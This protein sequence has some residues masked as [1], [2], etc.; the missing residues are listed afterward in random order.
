MQRLSPNFSV[1]EY[2]IEERS[3]G[4]TLN[5]M[6]PLVSLD[7]T[8]SSQGSSEYYGLSF[9][10]IR[11]LGDVYLPLLSRLSLVHA[12]VT[13]DV[14][15]ALICNHRKTL[16]HLN[17]RD[18]RLPSPGRWRPVLE[19]LLDVAVVLEELHLGAMYQKI[20][21]LL[22]KE[23]NKRGYYCGYTQHWKIREGVVNG[24]G[25]F[26]SNMLVIEGSY[27]GYVCACFVEIL[28]SI[29]VL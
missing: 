14:L 24:L 9:A 1:N 3:L 12:Q 11:S 4:D 13:E 27:P 18:I 2:S 7:L 16:G 15:I 10:D 25:W 19:Y 17:L 23:T 21:K 20:S 26:L 28:I 22:D 29:A 6:Y 8:F 5:T